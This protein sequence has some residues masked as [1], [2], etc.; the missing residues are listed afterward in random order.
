M[1][2]PDPPR[3]FNDRGI[4]VGAV[5]AVPGEQANLFAVALDDQPV[6]VQLDFMEPVRPKENFLGGGRD[7]GEERCFTHAAQ[8]GAGRRKSEFLSA[9]LQSPIRPMIHI[10]ARFW[11]RDV[12][13]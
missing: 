7:P 5:V 1:V 3:R 11:S 13:S 10:N 2:G 6:A 9:S 8:M 4:P 12:S